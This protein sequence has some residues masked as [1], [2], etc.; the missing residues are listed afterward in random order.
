MTVCSTEI[1]HGWVFFKRYVIYTFYYC[2]FI[3]RDE[4]EFNDLKYCVLISVL[5][6]NI[7]SFLSFFFLSS[8]FGFPF[9]SRIHRIRSPGETSFSFPPLLPTCHLFLSHFPLFSFFSFC[10]FLSF[11]RA[12]PYILSKSKL[13]KQSMSTPRRENK[14][15]QQWSTDYNCI[16]SKTRIAPFTNMP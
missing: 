5:K 9:L 14:D 1:S 8:L 10:L 13:P 11:V 16:W 6:L 7:P 4:F 3:I 2:Y 12:P 15:K